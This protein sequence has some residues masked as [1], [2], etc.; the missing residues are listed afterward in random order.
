MCSAF[1]PSKC[2]HTVVNTHTVNTHP[3]Q[4]AVILLRRPGSSWGFGA[5]FKGLTSVVVLRVEES[6]SYSLPP[7]PTIPAEP[8]TQ[9]HDLQVTSPNLWPLG[10]DCPRISISIIIIIICIT[11][12]VLLFI[13]VLEQSDQLAL[14]LLLFLLLL[15]Y[16]YL[17]TYWNSQTSEPFWVNLINSVNKIKKEK[18]NKD[19]QLFKTLRPGFTDKA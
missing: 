4:W 6:A 15:F 10:H 16:Y 14:L 17:L 18:A 8:E 13:N 19:V 2:T 9:T 1:D 5:L 3:E 12:I 7:P 11:I